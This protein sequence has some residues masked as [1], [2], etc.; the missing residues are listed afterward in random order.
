MT[1]HDRLHVG[2]LF[3]DRKMQQ[4]FA[5]PL[6][7]ARDLVSVQVDRTQVFRIHKTFADHRRR[8]ENFVLPDANRNISVIGRGKAFVVDPPSDLADLFF[9]FAIV[10]AAVPLC[11][12]ECVFLS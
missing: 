12:H 4:D 3:H 11:A 8:T 7:L 5:G 1:V 2:T 6:P 9:Q 10:Y